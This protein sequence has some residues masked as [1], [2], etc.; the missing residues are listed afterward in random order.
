M[1]SSRL[2]PRSRGYYEIFLDEEARAAPVEE[3][4]YGATYLPR[5]FKI[6]LVHP[7][8]NTVDVLANDLGFVALFEG[9]ALQGYQVYVGGG[10]GMTHNNP[11]TY[12]RIASAVGFVGPDQLWDATVAVI[13]LQ[14][15]HGDRTNRRRA[16][17]KYVVDD[18]GLAWVREQL[19]HHLRPGAAAAARPAAVRSARAARLAR[20]GRRAAVAGRP[21]RCR[22]HRRGAARG[23]ARGGAA[24][25]R[26]ARVHPAAGRAADERCAGG[27]RGAGRAAARARRGAGGGAH[28]AVALG[29]GL[30]R[31]AH[32]RP[33]ADR[34]GA[35]A[36]ADRGRP[37]AALAP[38]RHGGRAHQPAHHRLPQRLRAVV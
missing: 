12:P 20:A 33:G 19:T 29:A 11:R 35:G 22:A 5:K 1:L 26:G 31:A 15:D 24:L 2:L 17:L 32:L 25:R 4:V 3:P 27:P 16:R 13:A 14:R 30:H 21:G 37:R 10:Q 34:G 23:A 9:D 8:D 36:P 7:A 18:R 38:P 28:P 6:G